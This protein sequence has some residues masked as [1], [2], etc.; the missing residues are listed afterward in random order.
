MGKKTKQ[1]FFIQFLKNVQ[2]Y[3]NGHFTTKKNS[4]HDF[5]R[6]GENP[7]LVGG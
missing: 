5:L 3:Q 2:F 4:T 6:V 7:L 1:L